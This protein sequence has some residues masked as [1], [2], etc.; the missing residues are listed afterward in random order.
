MIIIAVC[1]PIG[2][3]LKSFVDKLVEDARMKK[4]SVVIYSEAC[5]STALHEPNHRALLDKIEKTVAS[6][7]FVYGS[8][9]FLNQDLCK[10]FDIKIFMECDKD[11]CLSHVLEKNP[12]DLD[13]CLA[14]YLKHIKPLNDERICPSKRNADV[15]IFSEGDWKVTYDI[16]FTKIESLSE[17]NDEASLTR[18]FGNR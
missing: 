11:T 18:S 10:K 1:G 2:A 7:M 14:N 12:K 5:E 13:A 15:W 16:L 8:Q 6:V 3:P 17:D 4:N 9:L